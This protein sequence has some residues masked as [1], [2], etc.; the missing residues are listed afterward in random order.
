[1]KTKTAQEALVALRELI[2]AGYIVECSMLVKQYQITVYD[3]A[4]HH[5]LDDTLVGAIMKAHKA[6]I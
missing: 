3:I 2:D 4:H 5:H 6:S 1:M